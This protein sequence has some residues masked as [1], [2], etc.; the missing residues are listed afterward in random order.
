METL[1]AQIPG[2]VSISRIGLVPLEPGGGRLVAYL[3]QRTSWDS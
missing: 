3:E 1:T 2:L